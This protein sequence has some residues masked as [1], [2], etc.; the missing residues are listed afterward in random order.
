M[1][2]YTHIVVTESADMTIED[3]SCIG[4]NPGHLN[5]PKQPVNKWSVHI[6]A[7]QPLYQAFSQNSIAKGRGQVINDFATS[8]SCLLW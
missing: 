2:L 8:N 1:V 7:K 4:S 6:I 5:L 3:I